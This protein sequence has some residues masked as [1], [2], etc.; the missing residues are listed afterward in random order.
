MLTLLLYNGFAVKESA[1]KRSK[2]DE[3][4]DTPWAQEQ[5][6]K[7][8]A[9]EPK[10]P[11]PNTAEALPEG[12]FDDKMVDAKIRNAEPKVDALDEE[13]ARFQKELKILEQVNLNI[14]IRWQVVK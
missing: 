5:A 10:L 4:A 1:A 12:F 11:Q 13:L 6:E 7:R 9:A 14:N 2:L 3:S 8:E